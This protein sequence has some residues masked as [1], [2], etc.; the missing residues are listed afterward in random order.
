MLSLNGKSNNNHCFILAMSDWT[1][2][3]FFLG[4]AP[5]DPSRS[6]ENFFFGALFIYKIR[7]VSKQTETYS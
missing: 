6:I 1:V 4:F 5:C 2:L 3:N 7:P